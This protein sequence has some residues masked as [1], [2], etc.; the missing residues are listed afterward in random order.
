MA[1][2]VKRK[3]ADIIVRLVDDWFTKVVELKQPEDPG[4][5]PEV[6]AEMLRLKETFERVA[7]AVDEPKPEGWSEG[8]PQVGACSCDACVAKKVAAAKAAGRL[9]DPTVKTEK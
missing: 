3:A 6:K 2:D 1:S 8:N 7:Q 5:A 4:P 9:T